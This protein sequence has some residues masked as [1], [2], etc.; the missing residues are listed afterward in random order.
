[1]DSLFKGDWSVVVVFV[2]GSMIG[3][4]LAI[5]MTDFGRIYRINIYKVRKKY[6][7]MKNEK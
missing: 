2:I 1:M 5:K 3:K 6:E 7:K 4:Y